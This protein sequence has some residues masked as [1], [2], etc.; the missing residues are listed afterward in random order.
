MAVAL[1][2]ASANSAPVRLSTR[3]ASTGENYF[4]ALDGDIAKAK[5]DGPVIDLSKGNPDLPT[6][7]HVVEALARA[8]RTPENQ[9]YPPF[10][11][12]R[13][14]REAIALRYRADHG[15]DLDPD[16]Q[17]TCF[18]GAHEPLMALPQALLEA[19]DTIGIPDP[20][21]P[22]YRNAAELAGVRARPIP[23]DPARGFRPDFDSE[24]LAG[25]G[26]LLLNYPHNPTGATA[27]EAL[28]DE[29]LDSSRRRGTL[30]VNDF[31]YGSLDHG[32]GTAVSVLRAD[33]EAAWSLEI[34]TA[35]K[36]YSMA[37]WRF[38]WAVGN[39]DAIAALRTYQ[40]LAYSVI[41]GAVQ[42]AAEA[43]LRGD[44]TAA[45]EI[46]ATYRRRRDAMTASL[47]AGGWHVAGSEGA[48]FCWIRSP[49][50]DDEAIAAALLHEARV[51]VAPGRGFGARGAGWLRL[52]LVH[53]TAVLEEAARRL[54]AF[55]ESLHV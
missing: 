29:A 33:P 7:S 38:G 40:T 11:A 37:G 34:G 24:D 8:A 18:H 23:L 47:K 1:N 3:V 49:L 35:S 13:S 21:Y 19:G 43:A 6:P 51:A 20:G 42:D 12:K 4:A 55:K 30:L 31:A 28:W 52:S 50:P 9:A 46:A 44:Q 17:I 39:A 2:R 41:F 10:L 25:L 16:A 32:R 22:P 54:N 45:A 14:V 27:D 5:K 26:L 36:T 53:E 15:V 48:F